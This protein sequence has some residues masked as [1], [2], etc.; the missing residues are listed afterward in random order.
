M[1]KRALTAAHAGCQSDIRPYLAK[2]CII[3]TVTALP[4][5]KLPPVS[6]PPTYC[7][8]TDL[9]QTPHDVQRLIP[10]HAAPGV[11]VAIITN[12]G[13][14]QSPR[15]AKDLACGAAAHTKKP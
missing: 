12:L 3:A 9:P 11:R 13:A 5:V 4:G 2:R 15:I 14:Q 6:R 7:L 8:W 1:V 10:A